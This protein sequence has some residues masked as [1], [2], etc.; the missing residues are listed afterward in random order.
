MVFLFI[1]I[2]FVGVRPDLSGRIVYFK[3]ST[4]VEDR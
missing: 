1:F 2:I 3:G 4:G